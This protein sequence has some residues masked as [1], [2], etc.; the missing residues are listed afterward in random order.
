MPPDCVKTKPESPVR[1]H[2][3]DVDF[4]LNVC[5]TSE[6]EMTTPGR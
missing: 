4:G 1:L 2:D 6:K 5:K 3:T